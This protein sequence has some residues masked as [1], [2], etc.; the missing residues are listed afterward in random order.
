MLFYNGGYYDGNNAAI[1]LTPNGG[2]NHD[3]DDDAIDPTKSAL[4]PG[5]GLA[6]PSCWSNYT[7]GINGLM[8][9]IQGATAAITS[10]DFTFVNQGRTGVGNTAIV[11]ADLQVRAGEGA[12]GSDRVVVT[13]ADG[14]MLNGWLQV[15]IGTGFGLAAPDVCY[16]GSVAYD[17]GSAQ[18]SYIP[19]NATDILDARDNPK[20][21]P[22][23][24]AVDNFVDYNKDARV[25][26]T[27]ILGARDNTKLNPAVAVGRITR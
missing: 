14:A 24:A 27:D 5:G 1:N 7:K 9:D 23:S 12:G 11:P 18:S 25:N 13:F 2:T 16:W 21:V 4:L 6:Q 26:A 10:G 19:V 8:F 15:T 17:S 3:H 20:L 22:G